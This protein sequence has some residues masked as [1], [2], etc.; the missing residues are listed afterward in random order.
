MA[1]VLTTVVA[2]FAAVVTLVNVQEFKRR[3]LP[4]QL[5]REF[6]QPVYRT[7]SPGLVVVLGVIGVVLAFPL[8]PV[9]TTIGDIGTAGIVLVAVLGLALGV[10]GRRC[11]V[12][13][14]DRPHAYVDRGGR[15]AA[16]ERLRDP[17]P[18]A[19]RP[20]RARAAFRERRGRQ[21][22]QHLDTRP[23]PRKNR[24]TVIDPTGRRPE[25]ITPAPALQ[26]M[27]IHHHPKTGEFFRQIIM[28]GTPEHGMREFYHPSQHEGSPTSTPTSSARD[29]RYRPRE[30]QRSI[31]EDQQGPDAVMVLGPCFVPT[32]PADWHLTYSTVS[33]S[34]HAGSD[35]SR[36]QFISAAGVPRLNGSG[37]GHG[38]VGSWPSIAR[39]G[40]HI[41]DMGAKFL[42][43]RKH[44][45]VRKIR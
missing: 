8:A 37:C 9:I 45:G 5:A 27:D 3:W 1:V 29:R 36:S 34:V 24:P 35:P 20:S 28:R 38:E 10:A 18:Y 40:R 30:H 15:V 14:R 44:C 19:P 12:E 2:V 7:Y 32:E 17:P 39:A 22:H 23:D 21:Q 11:V 25:R 31:P 16:V 42:R 4:T 33:Y 26:I 13:S 43:G 6:A 41:A